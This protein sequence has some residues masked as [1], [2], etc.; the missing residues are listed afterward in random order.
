M[1]F[2]VSK[3]FGFFVQ[4]SNLFLCVGILGLV[5]TATRRARAGRALMAA[6]LLLLAVAGLSPLGNWLIEPLENRFPPWNPAGGAPDGI[7]VLGGA[8]SP[9]VSFPRAQ[10]GLNEAAERVTAAV[11]LA[12][13]YPAARLL[14]SGGNPWRRAAPG[15]ADVA[16]ALLER[17]GVARERIIVEN[18][19]RNTVENAVYSL[20]LAAPKPG[21]RWLL[22]TS[23]YHMPR[24]IGIFRRLGFDVEAY[25][26]DW[27]TA[28]DEGPLFP[29]DSVGSGLRRTDTAVRE[30][31]GLV[32]YFVTGRCSALFPAPLCPGSDVRFRLPP[33]P[34]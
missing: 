32:A 15:E 23:A 3:V 34:Y 12:R 8:I 4:P 18:K 20:E 11:E 29:F 22:V 28:G 7:V 13:R 25:P 26:V 14:Y 10:A 9:D 16:V 33:A 27:R 1:F 19:S 5:L 24:S 17:M 21:E 31:F 2:V 30:W 6:G